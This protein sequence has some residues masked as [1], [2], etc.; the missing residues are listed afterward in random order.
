MNTR[1]FTIRNADPSEFEEIGRLM[2]RV[3][4]NLDGFPKENEQPEYFRTLANVGNFTRK[5]DTSL[6]VAVSAENII[7][8]AL[9]YFDNMLYKGSGG[10]ASL[11]KNAS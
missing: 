7:M 3:Y 6:V 1:Q 4:S 5:P 9:V 11:E 2:V 8:G 10:S